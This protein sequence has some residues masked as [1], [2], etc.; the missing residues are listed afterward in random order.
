MHMWLWR[1]VNDVNKL[2]TLI[3]SPHVFVIHPFLHVRC[4]T[5]HIAFHKLFVLCHLVHYFPQS[6][7]KSPPILRPYK[8]LPSTLCH[9]GVYL[10]AEALCCHEWRI[11]QPCW[12]SNW[13]LERYLCT[14]ASHLQKSEDEAEKPT[15]IHTKIYRIR[16]V[17][18]KL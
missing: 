9:T 11:I 18:T 10:R 6:S 15:P 3:N 14:G 12:Y 4:H 16:I 17:G 8:S 13:E 7:S 1:H 2:T 5:G